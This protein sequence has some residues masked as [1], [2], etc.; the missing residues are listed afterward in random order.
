MNVATMAFM[1]LSI[2]ASGGALAFLM[3]QRASGRASPE[4]DECHEQALLMES[5]AKD[6]GSFEA[7]VEKTAPPADVQE[8]LKVARRDLEE[9][10]LGL[11]RGADLV[12]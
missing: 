4:V 2:A 10:I 5:F 3:G 8:E 12:L 1:F 9:A 11:R 6:L 7:D